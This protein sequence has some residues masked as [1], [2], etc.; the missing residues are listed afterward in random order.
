MEAFAFGT[1]LT[2]L[3]PALRIRDIDK[4]LD[5]ASGEILD[6]SG[7]TRIGASIKE[8]N[9]LWS[10]R[11]LGR[12]AIVMIISDGWDRGELPLLD[13][14]MSRLRRST[15]KLFWLNPLMGSPE[16]EPLVGGIQTVSPYVDQFLPI[17]NLDSLE[18]LA[19]QL[20]MLLIDPGY[21]L[22]MFRAPIES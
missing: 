10:R 6:W 22:R 13:V 15:A 12:R 21:S 17:H 2:R 3:T 20:G 9:Y 5:Q 11:V 8:F 14:E 16:Y 7:G 19:K 4:A 1:R 18:T